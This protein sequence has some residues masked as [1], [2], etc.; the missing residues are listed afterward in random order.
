[1]EKELYDGAQAHQEQEVSFR[2]GNDKNV[3]MP[4]P[5]PTPLRSLALA[6]PQ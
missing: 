4:T 6:L 3:L 5:T 1:M 2:E